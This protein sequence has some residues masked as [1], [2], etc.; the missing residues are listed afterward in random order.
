MKHNYCNWAYDEHT[1]EKVCS[2]MIMMKDNNYCTFSLQRLYPDASCPDLLPAMGK[3]KEN[4]LNAS[5]IVLGIL[6]V[7][8]LCLTIDLHVRNEKIFTIKQFQLKEKTTGY[9][10]RNRSFISFNRLILLSI[11]TYNYF[12]NIN[13]WKI[14]Y[15]WRII[16]RHILKS[17]VSWKI[18][19]SKAFS[20]F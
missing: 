11:V 13:V 12:T 7:F 14:S 20:I 17:N 8:L 10:K 1:F 2:S 5:L 6:N 3:A 4:F 15:V 18:I 19:N 9:K 16:H